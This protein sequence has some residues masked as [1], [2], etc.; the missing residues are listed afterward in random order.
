MSFWN[1]I[2]RGPRESVVAE[3]G[4]R[5]AALVV[6]TIRPTVEPRIAHMGIHESRGYVR[7]RA[8]YLIHEAIEMV[9]AHEPVPARPAKDLVFNATLEEVLRSLYR[10]SQS[11]YRTNR[12]AA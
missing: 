4:R 12:R 8:G 7:A 10:R 3:M 2:W 1:W 9:I 5:A 6:E 11:G